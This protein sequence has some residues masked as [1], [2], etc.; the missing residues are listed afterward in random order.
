M[1]CCSG[2]ATESQ[3]FFGNGIQED[4]RFGLTPIR[5]QEFPLVVFS[6]GSTFG[7][8]NN[9]DELHMTNSTYKMMNMMP[10]YMTL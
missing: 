3:V 2:N 7:G 6:G 8:K 9:I 10:D 1:L 5:T 4:S